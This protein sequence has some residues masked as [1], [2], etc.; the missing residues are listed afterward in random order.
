MR[1]NPST[2][3]RKIG[4]TPIVPLS[5]K[6]MSAFVVLLLISTFST[7]YLNLVLNQRE[8]VKKTN[9]LLVKELKEIYTFSSNQYEIFQYSGD[10]AGA[11]DSIAT[12]ASRDLKS[13]HA[14]TFGL[15]K[16]GSVLFIA[17][18]NGTFST[19]PDAAA[20]A[21]IN[22]D[23]STGA[24]E[25]SIRFQGPGGEYFAVYKYLDKWDCYIVRAELFG[26][27][28]A[29]TNGIFRSISIIILILVIFFLVVG[30]IIINHILRFL[31]R[32]ADDMLKMQESQSLALINLDGAPN[33]DVAYLGASFNALSATINNLMTIFRKFV[34][35]DVVQRAYQEHHVRLEGKQMELAIL[36]SDIRGFTYMTETLGN[37]I[38]DLLNVHYNRA[39]KCIH[40]E[41]GIVGS[42]IGDAVLAVYGTMSASRNKAIESLVSAYAIQNVTASL[43]SEMQLRRAE[44][45]KT[46]KLTEAEERVFRAVLIDVG[47]GIDGGKVFYGNIGSVERMTNTVIGD[48]VNSSSRLE[49][50]T[51]IYQLPIICSEYIKNEVERDTDRYHFVEIDMVQVKG[52]TEGKRVFYP[53][54]KKVAT[55]ETI[56][57]FS[58]YSR[59][60]DLYYSGD[61]EA[62]RAEFRKSGL[63]TCQVFYERTGT[64][65]NAPEGWRG[66]WTMTTK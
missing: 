15:A 46:R 42:I 28:L 5:F 35:Q 33:D 66:I 16:S 34:T 58:Q 14:M 49:G 64:T 29:S 62:A 52:K 11:L 36:F 30:L 40:D 6:I 48:N 55:E 2:W 23:R 3:F 19:F 61:W 31:K 41:N 8:I 43:R 45:E 54:D 9:E 13:A 63:E 59:G 4:D 18:K 51:R 38:I 26:D 20:L 57:Q 60:L 53:L 22:A 56:A 17:T 32:F 65:K 50:L 37:D 12:N 7:N 47:V 25:G 39:I 10:R 24:G 27:M 1:L 44:I 21:K